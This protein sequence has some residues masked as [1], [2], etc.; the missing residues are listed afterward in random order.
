MHSDRSPT[1]NPRT[2]AASYLARTVTASAIIRKM[3]NQKPLLKRLTSRINSYNHG[4]SEL[5]LLTT[6]SHKPSTPTNQETRF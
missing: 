2:R 6:N 1:M 4:I 3:G 5:N